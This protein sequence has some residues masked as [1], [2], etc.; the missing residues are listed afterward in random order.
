MISVVQT[1]HVNE[2]DDFS[3]SNKALTCAITAGVP[4]FVC[5]PNSS[6]LCS[7]PVQI[8]EDIWNHLRT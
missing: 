2:F 1:D 8:T 3:G 7:I 5:I 4:I 6:V